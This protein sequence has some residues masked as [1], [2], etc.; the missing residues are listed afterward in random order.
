MK[1]YSEDLRRKIVEATERRH[2][3]TRAARPFGVSL[4]SVKRYARMARRGSSLAPKEGSGRPAKLEENAKSLLEVDVEERPAAT[5]PDGRRFPE[6]I[7]GS[8]LSDSTVRRP[9]WR[10]GPAARV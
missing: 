9:R 7:T 6:R 4:S 1:A 3:K 8:S 5:F 10:S 2:S